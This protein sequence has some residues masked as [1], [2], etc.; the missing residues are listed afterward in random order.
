MPT[1]RLPM[2]KIRS[3]RH[4]PASSPGWRPNLGGP[5]RNSS[6][7]CEESTRASSLWGN[8]GHC[9]AGLKTGVGS[10]PGAWFLPSRW[11]RPT[12]R[13]RTAGPEQKAEASLDAACETEAGRVAGRAKPTSAPATATR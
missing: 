11:A 13:H 2:R 4:G 7:V 3:R 5:R 1:P 9:S 8:S 10:L 6:T 12:R